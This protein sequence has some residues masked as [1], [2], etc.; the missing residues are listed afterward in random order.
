[1]PIKVAKMFSVKRV[2]CFTYLETSNAAIRNIKRP[3]KI[4]VHAKKGQKGKECWS[5]K[6]NN[7]SNRRVIGPVGRR[8]N[9]G[10][11][12]MMEWSMPAAL[13]IIRYSFRPI[14]PLVDSLMCSPNA[15][16]EVNV[17]KNMKRA[18]EMVFLSKKQLHGL[19]IVSLNS[20]LLP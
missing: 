14:S 6:V 18:A 7:F 13:F 19:H 10:W 17:A 11:Q 1:M 8:T 15:R 20:T 9:K 4:P 16:V 2:R 12:P 5:A 3:T